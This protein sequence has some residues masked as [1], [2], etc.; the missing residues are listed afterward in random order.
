[1]NLYLEYQIN[2]TYFLMFISL[3]LLLG[4]FAYAYLMF[5]KKYVN[6]MVLNLEVIL[7][8]LK[9]SQLYLCYHIIDST[10]KLCYRSP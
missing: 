10:L 2:K 3:S 9:A 8:Y 6:L 7:F 4:L 5:Q 1:M